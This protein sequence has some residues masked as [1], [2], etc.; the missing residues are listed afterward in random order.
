MVAEKQVLMHGLLAGQVMSTIHPVKPIPRLLVKE[1][2][3]L[4]AQ[5]VAKC[6]KLKGLVEPEATKRH[7][8]PRTEM[9]EVT[10]T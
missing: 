5:K 6:E 3:G 10:S 2:R 7:L 1:I 4:E 9:G 8:Q